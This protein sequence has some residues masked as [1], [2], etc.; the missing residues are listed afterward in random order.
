MLATETTIIASS[1]LASNTTAL[2][3]ATNKVASFPALPPG[4]EIYDLMGSFTMSYPW[5]KLVGEI[6]LIATGFVI[7][8]LFYSWITTPVERKR[9]PIVQSPETQALRAIKR[10]KLS[11]IWEQHNT[12][13]ICENVAAIIKN[14]ALDAYKVSIGAAATTDEFVYAII[15][16]EIKNTVLSEIKE[17]LEYCDEVRYTGNYTERFS[18]EDLVKSLE[19]LINIKGWT[20]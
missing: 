6:A 7:I 4:E 1:T 8:Y 5:L 18:Q 20:K 13:A 3:S 17:M 19:N 9:K 2:A 12:K 15:N 10:L 11:E 14:Y 16:A